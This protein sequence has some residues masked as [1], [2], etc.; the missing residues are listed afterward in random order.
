ML[1]LFASVG[2]NKQ[3]WE[4]LTSRTELPCTAEAYFLPS[5]AA[6]P[7]GDCG[8]QYR[9]FQFRE[10]GVMARDGRYHAIYL[11]DASKKGM[12]FLSPVQVFPAE[13]VQLLL[14]E[15]GLID[16]EVRRCR[17]LRANCYECGCI[18]ADGLASTA[19]Y[20]QLIQRLGALV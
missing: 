2:M 11:K 18:F 20:K 1:E 19:I 14:A 5:G 17:R 12:G 4:S 9:R 7:H 16:L 13:R 15:P 10:K 6:A 8:R 3:M